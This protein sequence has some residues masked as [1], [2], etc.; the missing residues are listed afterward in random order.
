MPE[1]LTNDAPPAAGASAEPP[2]APEREL[3]T[4]QESFMAKHDDPDLMDT[5]VGS[6]EPVEGLTESSG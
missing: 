2:M 5:I 3:P 6:G 1:D 4:G